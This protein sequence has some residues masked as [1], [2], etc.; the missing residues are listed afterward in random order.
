MPFPLLPGLRAEL[1]ETS[2]RLH[3]NGWVA[4]HDGNL[5][6]RLKGD[7]FLI[8]ATA[9]SKRDVDDGGLLVVDGKG[10]VLEGRRK[11]FSELELHLACY[12]ARPEVDAVL[13][14]HPPVATAF[15]LVGQGLEPVAMPEIVVSL[16]A[17][18]PAVPRSIPRDPQ[19]VKQVEAHAAELDAFLLCG[20]GALALGA[21]LNQALLRMELVEHYA[22]ILHAA[23]ALGPVAPLADADRDKLLEARKKAGLGPRK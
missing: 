14:A 8:T 10:N 16:G 19:G 4:N 15:G 5:S 3:E 1:V 20:N 18:I 17:R 9:L 22:R 13:H 11:P 23:R 12:R 21:D 2:R 7:R 6:V